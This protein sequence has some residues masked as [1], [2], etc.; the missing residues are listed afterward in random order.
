VASYRIE[1]KRSAAKEIDKI[2]NRQDRRRIV[3]RIAKLADDPRPPGCRKLGG[4]ESYR[5]RQGPYRIIYTIEDER[6][7]V[8][9]VKVGHRREIYR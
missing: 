4:R 1:L 5:I 8:T 7:L 9:V 3:E 2:N 6:L